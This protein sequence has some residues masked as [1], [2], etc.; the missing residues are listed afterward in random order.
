MEEKKTPITTGRRVQLFMWAQRFRK[1]KTFGIGSCS[2]VDEA[3]EDSELIEALNDHTSFEA[4]WN[5]MC[6]VEET[7][8]EMSGISWTRPEEIE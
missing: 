3:M 5:F 6:E 1:S 7:H 4:A 8:W 2:T